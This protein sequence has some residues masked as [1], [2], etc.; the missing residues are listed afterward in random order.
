MT[1]TDITETI[2]RMFNAT[3][4]REWRE[5]ERCFSS[6]VL[7]D[8]S[9]MTGNP[10]SR[11]SP[12]QITQ[13][14]KQVL[15]GFENTQHMISNFEVNLTSNRAHIFCKGIAYHFLPHPLGDLWIVAGTYDFVLEDLGGWKITAMKFDISFQSGNMKLPGLAM[16]NA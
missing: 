2:I 7:L 5:V 3:D 13:S 16:A 10:A 12:S 15:P 11:V 1:S 14:W 4:A 6:N 8:Y 9:S